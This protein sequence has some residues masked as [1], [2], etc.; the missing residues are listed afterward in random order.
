MGRSWRLDLRGGNW[1][2]RNKLACK[3]IALSTNSDLLDMKT[4]IALPLVA[5][6]L[7]LRD[8]LVALFINMDPLSILTV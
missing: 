6:C 3:N 2:L 8:L 1:T 5:G 4:Q 7:K